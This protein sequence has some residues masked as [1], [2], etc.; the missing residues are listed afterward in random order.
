MIREKK[1]VELNSALLFII[2]IGLLLFIHMRYLNE[3]ST[4]TIVGDEFGYWATGAALAGEN[5]TGI[6]SVTPY[7]SYGYGLILAPLIFI[8]KNPI[9]LYKSAILMNGI[10]MVGCMSLIYSSLKIIFNKIDYKYLI[11]I[12]FVSCC[13][14][15]Y[16]LHSNIAWSEVLITFTYLLLLRM[17]I[18]LEVKP[19]YLITIIL[20]IALCFSYQIHQRNIAI[21]IAGVLCVSILLLTK[22]I[23][24]KYFLSFVVVISMMFIIHFI[25]KNWFMDNLWLA[26]INESTSLNDY[27][28]QIDKL[29]S[30]FT[31]DGIKLAINSLIGKI[32][33]HITSSYFLFLIAFISIVCITFKN[34]IYV[35][36]NIFCKKEYNYDDFCVTN[37][38][39]FLSFA[40]T[41]MIA[42]I[43]MMY[44][45]RVDTLIYGRYT[46]GLMIPFLAFGLVLLFKIKENLNIKSILSMIIFACVSAIYTTFNMN[47]YKVDTFYYNCVPALSYFWMSGNSTYSFIAQNVLFT[48]AIFGILLFLYHNKFKK[49]ILLANMLLLIIF[50]YMGN[51]LQIRNVQ[52]QVQYAE[53]YKTA[54]IIEQLDDNNGIYCI[55]A[56]DLK[57]NFWVDSA[58]LQYMLPK[59][60]IHL[61]DYNNID[62]VPNNSILLVSQTSE[63]LRQIQENFNAIG[64]NMSY[65][66]LTNKNKVE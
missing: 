41:L 65:V 46:D 50:V 43:S 14:P 27:T 54:E 63:Y 66:V 34:S 7:Y 19:N 40:G 35:I 20:A 45:S 44:P 1:K 59:E 8:F 62:S 2:C 47:N 9:L 48:I 17:F 5:W 15:S 60:T 64:R 13:F 53:N 42:S 11:I 49:L 33:Y 24:L 4:I 31:F 30:L 23:R 3:Y 29:N 57:S 12:S 36:L 56:T 18:Q 58:I 37:I 39:L 28:G 25:L 6:S 10:L 52:R 61:I 38:F 16:M 26:S 22:K 32:F 55:G 51:D 21:V